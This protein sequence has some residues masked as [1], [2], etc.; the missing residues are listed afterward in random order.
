[1]ET[2]AVEMT[3]MLRVTAFVTAESEERAAAIAWRCEDDGRPGET[4]EYSNGMTALDDEA[5]EVLGVYPVD[6][7]EVLKLTKPFRTNSKVG[8]A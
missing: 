7:D 1:M 5:P 8:N 2:Y 3:G 6:K 4:V